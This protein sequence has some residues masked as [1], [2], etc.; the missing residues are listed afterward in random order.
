MIPRQDLRSKRGVWGFESLCRHCDSFAVDFNRVM[1]IRVV[2]IGSFI[3][4]IYS[5]RNSL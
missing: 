5:F 4:I 1:S 3:I 2:Y